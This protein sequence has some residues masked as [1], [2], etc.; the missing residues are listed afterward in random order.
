MHFFNGEV[1]TGGAD[2]LNY[3]SGMWDFF[4]LFVSASGEKKKITIYLLT[5]L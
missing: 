4:L 1:C 2:E 3:L 5:M